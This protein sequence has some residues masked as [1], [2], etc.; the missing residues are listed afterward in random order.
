M[1]EKFNSSD[2]ILNVA[3]L[4]TFKSSGKYDYVDN[5][6]PVLAKIIFLE[7]FEKIDISKIRDKIADDLKIKFPEAS[8]DAILRRAVKKELLKKEYG[9]YVVNKELLKN[10]YEKYVKNKAIIG[11]AQKDLAEDFIIYSKENFNRDI[12]EEK[13]YEMFFLYLKE[14]LL[15]ILGSSYDPSILGRSSNNDS[16]LVSSFLKFKWNRTTGFPDT[17]NHNIKG[18][19]LSNYLS[20]ASIGLSE[21]FKKFKIYIDTPIIIAALGYN[22]KSKKNYTLEFLE[23]L[24]EAGAELLWLSIN[25]DELR[26]VLKGW[27]EDLKKGNHKAFKVHTIRMFHNQGIDAVVLERHL[28]LLDSTIS[29]LGLVK[30]DK[31]EYVEKIQINEVKLKQMLIKEGFPDDKISTDRDVD[32]LSAINRFRKGK[33]V[34]TF[35]D[36][37]HVFLTRNPVL[38]RVANEFFFQEELCD[39]SAIP[40]ILGEPII[41]SLL[42]ANHSGKFHELGVKMLLGQ[43]YSFI[44]T[45]DNFLEKFS[46][47]LDLLR[48]EEKLTE[49][50]YL[51]YRYDHE[52]RSYINSYRVEKD[53]EELNGD[54]FFELLNSL[55]KREHQK[56]KNKREE[57][58]KELNF[59]RES[60]RKES[61][62][63]KNAKNAHDEQKKTNEQLLKS[64]M[65]MNSTNIRLLKIIRGFVGV[66]TLILVGLFIYFTEEVLSELGKIAWGVGVCINIILFYYGFAGKDLSEL[67]LKFIVGKKQ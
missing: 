46:R 3:L 22:G 26:G 31:P 56:D 6:L 19:L 57:Q 60:L 20:T 62:K 17:I 10:Y 35:N 11:A 37:L 36:E 41:A 65:D 47:R 53:L 28:A 54:D 7:K 14:N 4:D 66:L 51:I 15:D 29:K 30:I 16:F 39:N 1:S 55:K 67:I 2:T 40:P 27:I 43:A 34:F 5:F 59:Y 38:R 48:D 8:I 52:V 33:K 24:K 49:D 23:S 9:E 25:D 45:D 63:L 50:E 18:F 44:F 42:L 32:C 12:K 64:N 58:E 13:F 21:Q 61:D